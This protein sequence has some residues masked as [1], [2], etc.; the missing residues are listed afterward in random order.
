VRIHYMAEANAQPSNAL[1]ILEEL[2]ARLKAPIRLVVFGRGAL[3]LGFEPPLPKWAQTLDLDAITSQRL[4]P[5]SKRREFRR[6]RI[7][8]RNSKRPRNGSEA[9]IARSRQISGLNEQ[10][11]FDLLKMGIDRE[12]AK[13]TGETPV[14]RF[15]LF[16][17]FFQPVLRVCSPNGW[18]PQRLSAPSSWRRCCP[19]SDG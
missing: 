3:A 1:I 18:P 16:H 12:G 13:N 9:L 14:P 17:S 11:S 15:S 6:S 5:L 8:G 4:R 2:D 19:G 7:Y 10:T